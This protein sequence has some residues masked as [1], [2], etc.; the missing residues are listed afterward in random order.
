MIVSGF[1]PA[2]T[3]DLK[4]SEGFKSTQIISCC[5]DNGES[6]AG[7]T[8]DDENALFEHGIQKI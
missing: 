3:E 2:N 8:K 5:D 6:H 1:K 7:Q 4:S